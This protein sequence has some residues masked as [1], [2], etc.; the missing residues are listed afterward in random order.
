MRQT[1]LNKGYM[2]IN[3]PKRLWT[4]QTSLTVLEIWQG[5]VEA[6]GFAVEWKWL[7]WVD[8]AAVIP[9]TAT[10]HGS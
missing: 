3:T 4:V 2:D 10:P 7:W 5:E 8:T 6:A 9:L 1:C